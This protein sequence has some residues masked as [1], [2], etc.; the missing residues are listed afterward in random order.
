M[1]ITKIIETGLNINSPIDVYSD[2]TNNIMN[3]LIQSFEGTC[4]RGCYIKK[5]LKIRAIS[6]CILERRG[7]KCFGRVNIQFEVEA[8]LYVEGEVINGCEVKHKD[9]NAAI[10]ISTSQYGT[11]CLN[12]HTSLDSIL[13]GQIISV[14]VGETK[15]NPGSSKISINAYPFFPNKY[16][17]S[18]IVS[19][20]ISSENAL[21][22]KDKSYLSN[23]IARIAYE[24]K[25]KEQLLKVNKKGWDFFDNLL[26]AYR[27]KQ[28]PPKGI[29]VVEFKKILDNSISIGWYSRDPKISPSSSTVFVSKESPSKETHVLHDDFDLRHIILILLEDYCDGLKNIREMMGIYNTE[30]K[31]TKHR[32]FWKILDK[33]KL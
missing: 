3:M 33:G 6:E 10:I 17:N 26:N 29:N 8:V 31:F 14:R 1:I 21:S 20:H 25:E 32:N 2:A 22:E 27:E 24:E 18:K 4:L 23:V 28:S 11:I 5:I 19:Y 9:K 12:A 15:Y 30:E 13:I 7:E 16:L